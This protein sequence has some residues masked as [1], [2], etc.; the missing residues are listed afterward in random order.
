[1][2]QFAPRSRYFLGAGVSLGPRTIREVES[3]LQLGAASGVRTYPSVR[4][5]AG[6][7]RRLQTPARHLQVL[8]LWVMLC[9]RVDL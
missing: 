2:P 4:G 3:R 1:M 7:V 8:L 6:A 9:P 5:V